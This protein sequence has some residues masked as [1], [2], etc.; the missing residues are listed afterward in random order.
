MDIKLSTVYL[1]LGSNMGERQNNLEKAME[2]LSQRMRIEKRSSIYDTAP[3][4]DIDQP[5]FL[6]MAC[7]VATSIPPETL[8]FLIK[9]IETKVGRT[10]APRNSPRIID[11][12][13]LLYDDRIIDTPDLKIPHPRMTERAFV[14][15]PLA[16]IAADALH[17]VK[18]QTIKDLLKLI[19]EGTQG[20]MK[21]S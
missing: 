12:D 11:I 17:P 2:Y 14:L 13:I 3:I 19:R 1:G 20:V 5:R 8:L 21:M 7:Q 16:E 6:N 18:N 15:M 4:G 10:A 9:G